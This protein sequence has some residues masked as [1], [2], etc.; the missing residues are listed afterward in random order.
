MCR[1][2]LLYNIGVKILKIIYI[3]KLENQIQC[4]L[5][6]KMYPDEIGFIYSRQR[7]FIL[8]NII[9]INK[10]LDGK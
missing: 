6:K 10:H 5:K 2:I 1:S 3:Q 4:V 9:P 8:K 7:G